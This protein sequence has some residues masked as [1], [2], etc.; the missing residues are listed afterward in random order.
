[1]VAGGERHDARRLGLH[2]ALSTLFVSN[3]GTRRKRASA[4][5]V[6]G[7]IASK[8]T[9]AHART[10]ATHMDTQPPHT[11]RPDAARAQAHAQA[12]ACVHRV[13][14]SIADAKTGSTCGCQSHT[15]PRSSLAPTRCRSSRH[16]QGDRGHRAHSVS[17]L[18]P[19]SA[20]GVAQG[21]QRCSN[22]GFS[23][24]RATR[25]SASDVRAHNS[26]SPPR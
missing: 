26:R 23:T 19:P 12:H 5:Y 6:H 25:I 18:P 22:R 7:R 21:Q 9:Q 20:G 1:M 16:E 14:G 13:T 15:K 10:H 2:I 4:S 11:R 3:C 8:H 24:S 17:Q